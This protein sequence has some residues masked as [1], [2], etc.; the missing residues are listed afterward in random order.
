MVFRHSLLIN[1]SKKFLPQ[2][3]FCWF[4]NEKGGYLYVILLDK[5]TL[6]VEDEFSKIGQKYMKNAQIVFFKKN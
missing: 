6:Q 4:P 1:A 2:K 5:I 3:S